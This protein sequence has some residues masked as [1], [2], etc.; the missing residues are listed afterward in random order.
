MSSGEI[1]EGLSDEQEELLLDTGYFEVSDS[2]GELAPL[3]AEG[4]EP[5][6][7]EMAD[8]GEVSQELKAAYRMYRDGA[9]GGGIWIPLAMFIVT[10]VFTGFLVVTY[11][12]PN[13]VQKASE[14]VY[15]STEQG[16]PDPLASAQALVAQGE[17]EGAIEAYRSAAEA[18][19]ENRLPWVEIAMLQRE[20]LEDSDLALATLDAAIARGNW[21][22]NDEAFFY[23][24]KI[25]I[26]EEDKKEHEKAVGLL[27]EVIEK[28]PNTR[29]MANAMH[30]LR[31]MG[32]SA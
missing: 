25:A 28:F 22:E 12:L 16:E 13:L 20:R 9:E 31:E 4:N 3:W 15:G 23:F 10:G 8:G 14:E 30:K 32:E 18:Q 21:R 11:L 26:F 5:S 6:L 17:W 24:R 1:Q 29:H 19:P 7:E 2:T 27:K